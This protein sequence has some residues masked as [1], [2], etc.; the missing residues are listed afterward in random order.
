MRTEPLSSTA[1]S[2]PFSSLFNGHCSTLD[3]VQAMNNIATDSIEAGQYNPAIISLQT[4]LRLWEHHRST[5]IPSNIHNDPSNGATASN[6]ST[7]DGCIAFSEQQRKSSCRYRRRPDNSTAST[8]AKKRAICAITSCNDRPFT[9]AGFKRGPKRRRLSLDRNSNNSSV[10]NHHTDEDW[11][12][13]IDDVDGNQRAFVYRQPIRIPECNESRE[14]VCFFVVMFNLALARHLK[15][16][17]HDNGIETSATDLREVLALYELLFEYWTRELRAGD[18]N[19]SSSRINNIGSFRFAM[20]LFNNLAHMYGM[21]NNF[22]KQ[23][24]CLRRLLSIVMVVVEHNAR[25]R[26]STTTT[27]TTTTG[28]D[29]NDEPAAFQQSIDG[30][31]AN[32]M[33]PEQHCAQAA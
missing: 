29:A 11:F 26:T 23:H 31:L 5:R 18:S 1:S 12:H 22:A 14:S 17:D 10:G 16:L 6:N 25:R 33:P 24:Q 7:L 13:R 2:L 21:T 3:A 30:F 9:E 4:A 20:V 15:I 19:S 28:G 27:T 8:T 32:A